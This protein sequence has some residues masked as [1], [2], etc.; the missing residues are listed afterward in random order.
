MNRQ[1]CQNEYDSGKDDI[2]A[3]LLYHAIKLI[4]IIV[5]HMGCRYKHVIFDLDGTI[6]DPRMGVY[7]SYHHAASKLN[8][9][10][11]TEETL[12][13]LIGPPLQKGFADV[14]G[15]KGP[16]IDMA[17]E[18]FREYYG[19]KGLYENTLF[20][21]M[22]ELFSA[23]YNTGAKIYVATS[24]YEVYARK[25]LESFNLAPFLT[26]VAG[27]D[28]SGYHASK[29]GLLSALL[30]RNGIAD[31]FDVVMVGDTFYDIEAA[32][33]LEIDS[34]G[35]TYGFTSLEEIEKLNPDYI[36]QSVGELY[37]LLIC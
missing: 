30:L 35:V 5:L 6:S 37:H 18:A 16:E 3:H 29:T 11:P 28:Y 21:G 19:D 23:L 17:V 24:K 31:P 12:E 15:L 32:T 4:K 14:F 22:P 8:L 20:D 2:F 10:I 26:D 13:T 36:A 9:M 27:A 7:H 1:T 33:E 34:I 25:V